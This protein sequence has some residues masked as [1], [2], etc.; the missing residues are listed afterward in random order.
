MLYET[1]NGET[2]GWAGIIAG[3]VN[4]V[5]ATGWF[6]MYTPATPARR[7]TPAR[8]HATSNSWM[9][10]RLPSVIGRVACSVLVTMTITVAERTMVTIE[11]W[12]F[13][14]VEAFVEYLE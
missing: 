5:Y 13:M 11:T 1:G 10:W 6:F 9:G 3:I 8:R 4:E 12:M 7:T 14:V 2:T